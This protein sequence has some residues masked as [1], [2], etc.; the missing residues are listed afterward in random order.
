M[1]SVFFV[2]MLLC[3]CA[4][5]MAETYSIVPLTGAGPV[6]IHAKV[7]L[8]NG[9]LF[10]ENTGATA[11]KKVHLYAQ[12]FGE[13]ENFTTQLASVPAHS[14]T[15]VSLALF[16]RGPVDGHSAQRLD[17]GPH[18]EIDDLLI[19]CRS[20]SYKGRWYGMDIGVKSTHI[21]MILL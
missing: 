15:R 17:G 1:K 5:A 19:V 2:L 14:V 16:R 13:P 11:W 12:C 10:I 4:C 3:L 18:G 7:T 20:A 6:T 8:K 21:N 9:T